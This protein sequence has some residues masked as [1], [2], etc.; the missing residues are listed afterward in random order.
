MIVKG[1]V[2][3]IVA[4]A[5]T[6]APGVKEFPHYGPKNHPE[7]PGYSK[8]RYDSSHGQALVAIMNLLR[9]V[10]TTPRSRVHRGIDHTLSRRP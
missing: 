3:A 10:F 7:H 9:L 8:P 4:G 5:A 2:A 1:L 6:A